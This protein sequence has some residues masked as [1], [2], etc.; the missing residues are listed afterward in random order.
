MKIFLLVVLILLLFN[1]IKNT[2]SALS[3][4]IYLD[5]VKKHIT[6]NGKANKHVKV[7]AGFLCLITWI[8]CITLY[9]I[10][11]GK[12]NLTYFTVLSALQ[13]V[14]V[15]YSI[16]GLFTDNLFSNDTNDFKF[17]RA[18]FLFRVILNYVYYPMAIYLLMK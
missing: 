1:R 6:N 8:L 7:L 4:R 11:A 13:I 14:T 5:K 3:K 15:L 16:A 12:F 18:Y 10:L 2:P 9:I 17:R